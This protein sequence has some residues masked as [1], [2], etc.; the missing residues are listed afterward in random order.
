MRGGDFSASPSPKAV[1]SP[2]V[3]EFTVVIEWLELEGNLE[4]IPLILQMMTLPPLTS[5]S[6]LPLS[7]RRARQ[8]R[9]L[10]IAGLGWAGLSDWYCPIFEKNF[11]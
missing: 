9:L 4:L 10:T 7:V 1:A 8:V 11:C 3:L 2:L 6:G 5:A